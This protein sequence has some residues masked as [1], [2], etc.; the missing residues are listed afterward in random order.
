MTSAGG[1]MNVEARIV[2]RAARTPHFPTKSH[3]RDERRR[4]RSA[5]GVQQRIDTQIRLRRRTPP[6]G[7]TSSASRTKGASRSGSEQTATV[8][9]P[10]SRQVRMI[11]RAI[12]PRFAIR[13]LLIESGGH[14]ADRESLVLTC[15]RRRTSLR[16]HFGGHAAESAMP[17]T[18]RV[19]RG[20]MMPSSKMRALVK[21]A[22]DSLSI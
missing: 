20:S 15:G 17:S 3:S 1:P 10:I 4:A 22:S 19:S 12:S 7:T 8:A 21:V 2:T 6:S 9:M 18:V 5:R 13:I 16:L 14:R 11:R